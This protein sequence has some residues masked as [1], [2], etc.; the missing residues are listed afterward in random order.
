MAKTIVVTAVVYSFSFGVSGVRAQFETRMSAT[1]PQAADAERD[2]RKNMEQAGANIRLGKVELRFNAGIRQE[3]NDNI[4]LSNADH[5]SD[6]IT[7]P[8]LGIDMHWPVSQLNSLD[9]TIGVAVDRYW[10]HPKAGGNNLQLAPNSMLDFNVYIADV[11][12]N[13]HDRFSIEQDPS[14]ATQLSNVTIFRRFMNM[15]GLDAEWDLNTFFVGAS[16]DCQTL[17]PLDNQYSYL[18][19]TTHTF[20][21]R[22]GW[23]TNPQLTLGVMDSFALTE[24]DQ[25]FQNNSQS[26][27]FG[28]FGDIILSEY[29]HGSVSASLQQSTF[30]SNGTVGDTSGFTSVVFSGSLLNQLNRWLNHSIGVSRYTTLGIGSN[31]TDI[32]RFNY[33]VTAEVIRNFDTSIGFFY[34]M[35]S[36]SPSALAENGDRWGVTP[37][38]GYQLA[39][40]TRLTLGYQYSERTS[41]V[42]ANAYDQSMI[43]VDMTHQF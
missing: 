38:L 5:Q 8:Y 4:G 22:V 27:S 29:L 30:D 19:H 16:Y 34:E 26:L 43:F 17:L 12:V 42:A 37:T 28:V 24:Y 31:F 40:T 11:R 18:E 6:F 14:T 36:D 41:N 23:R 15:A 10:Q 9:A 1:G 13:V 3:Y 21:N 39:A 33:Y 2:A 7:R 35:Y 25:N 20:G 32:Y